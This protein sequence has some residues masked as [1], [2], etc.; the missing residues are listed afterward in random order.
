MI[1][2][3]PIGAR[4]RTFPTACFATSAYCAECS[5]ELLAKPLSDRDIEALLL[6][7]LY[8]LELTDAAPHA[9]VNDA[10]EACARL[11]KTSV[12]GLV[13]A[14][15]RGFLRQREALVE[16][17]RAQRRGPLVLSCCG[18]SMR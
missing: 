9:V 3:C 8:Q 16:N 10:V 17:A 4:C 18:G 13:N 11:H 2:P 15:L 14:V 7:A 6:V 1:F 12:K 5:R